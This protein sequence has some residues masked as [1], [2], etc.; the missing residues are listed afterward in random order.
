MDVLTQSQRE[1]LRQNPATRLASQQTEK[2]YLARM[3]SWLENAIDPWAKKH[4]LTRDQAISV[5]FDDNTE[6]VTA[7]DCYWAEANDFSEAYRKQNRLTVKIEGKSVVVLD[8]QG[9]RWLSLSKRRDGVV[10]GT[11]ACLPAD[12]D[13]AETIARAY[14]DA[15]DLAKQL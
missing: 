4:G 14:V 5:L 8:A 13:A 12:G 15:F 11:S 2:A 9:S 6:G 7:K 3:A 1:L 10:V